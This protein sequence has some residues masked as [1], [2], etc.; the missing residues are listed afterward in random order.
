MLNFYK[1]IELYR[2]QAIRLLFWICLLLP[3]DAGAEAVPPTLYYA[4]FTVTSRNG[5]IT[6]AKLELLPIETEYRSEG[7]QCLPIT[8]TAALNSGLDLGV[9]ARHDGLIRILTIYGLKSVSA[10]G[11]LLNSRGDDQV[12]MHYEGVFRY[13]FRINAEN[14]EDGVYRLDLAVEFSPLSFPD[15]WSYLSLKHEIRKTFFWVLG[16]FI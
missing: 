12:Q 4:R 10:Q 13:P 14:F 2:F 15:R 11:R 6:A 1:S 5:M 7:F 9:A 3:G 16:F 8:G